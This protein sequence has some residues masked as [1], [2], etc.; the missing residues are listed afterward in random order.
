M[1]EIFMVEQG[2]DTALWDYAAGSAAV[3]IFLAQVPV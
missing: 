1:A 2:F 3:S